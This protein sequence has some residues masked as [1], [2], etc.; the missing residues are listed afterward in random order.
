MS[1]ILTGHAQSTTPSESAHILGTYTMWRET[2][3][4]DCISLSSVFRIHSTELYWGFSLGEP[5]TYKT[6]KRLQTL[7][8][9]A[10][11]ATMGCFWLQLYLKF[12]RLVPCSTA[13]PACTTACTT[14]YRRAMTYCRPD[15]LPK[16]KHKSRNKLVI[17]FVVNN[18]VRPVSCT[19][20]FAAWKL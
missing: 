15:Q 8:R 17:S 2:T 5:M 10:M 16:L 9:I 3:F 19:W 4:I 11:L 1:R 18:G 20:R 7:C 6:S 12:P 13:V 14:V